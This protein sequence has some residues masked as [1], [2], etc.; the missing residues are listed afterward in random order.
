MAMLPWYKNYDFII[1]ELIYLIKEN[2]Y[3]FGVSW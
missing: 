2:Y 1:G 3:K